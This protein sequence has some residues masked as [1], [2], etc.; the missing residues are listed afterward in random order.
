MFIVHSI[1]LYLATT[2]VISMTEMASPQL[3]FGLTL[4]RESGIADCFSTPHR[5]PGS[6]WT[7]LLLCQA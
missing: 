4:A 5:S 7:L 6:V 3:D 1:D 2:Q